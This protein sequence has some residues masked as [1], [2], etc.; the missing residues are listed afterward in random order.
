MPEKN[1]TYLPAKEANK[2]FEHLDYNFIKLILNQIC[3]LEQEVLSSQ[4]SAVKLCFRL[5]HIDP[6]KEL[7]GKCILLIRNLIRINPK[8][9]L[10][11]LKEESYSINKNE[12]ENFVDVYTIDY[13]D[14]TKAIYREINLRIKSIQSVNYKSLEIIKSESFRNEIVQK[15]KK[16]LQFFSWE[17]NIRQTIEL[18]K[19]ISI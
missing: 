3:F 4:K 17:E 6:G 9:F 10:E 18:Y 5:R 11:V 7:Y 15:L 1:I 13:T 8:L 12:F 19:R 2:Y 14:K 16:Q